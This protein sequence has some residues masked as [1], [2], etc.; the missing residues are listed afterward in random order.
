MHY[1]TKKLSLYIFTIF[2]IIT[3]N[4]L[5]WYC[6]LL[7]YMC[8]QLSIE[9]IYGGRK[10]SIVHEDIVHACVH[11]DVMYVCMHDIVD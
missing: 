6:K 11:G 1:N 10:T 8:Q 9:G 5:Q 3:K 7:C 4:Y 2:L